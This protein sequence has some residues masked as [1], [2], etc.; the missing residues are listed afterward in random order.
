M[1][2]PPENA[3][4]ESFAQPA[5]TGALRTEGNEKLPKGIEKSTEKNTEA[6]TS[7]KSMTAALWAPRLRAVSDFFKRAGAAIGGTLLGVATVVLFVP[8][9]IGA[10]TMVAQDVLDV[11]SA[12]PGYIGMALT[13]PAIG[14][15]YAFNYAFSR[16]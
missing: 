5:H 7:S 8:V 13:L 6:L 14:T 4:N 15:L 11:K 9:L 2:I 16:G 3:P 10:I 1:V 12:I